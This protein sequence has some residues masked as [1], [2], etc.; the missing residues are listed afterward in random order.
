MRGGQPAAE[1]QFPWAAAL[2]L[3]SERNSDHLC[4][5]ALIPGGS[6]D[7]RWVLTCA[8][9]MARYQSDPHGIQATLATTRRTDTSRN[10]SVRRIHVHPA[11][12]RR[13]LTTHDIAVVELEDPVRNV[14]APRIETE[15]SGTSVPAG[16]Q[17][18]VVGWG[19]T[20][21][22]GRLSEYL[23]CAVVERRCDPSLGAFYGVDSRAVVFAGAPGVGI[24]PGDSGSA[25]VIGN[26]NGHA[27]VG[28]ASD[29]GAATADLYTATAPYADWIQAVCQ[30]P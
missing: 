7:S 4:C 13:R 16:G 22:P 3:A 10:A 21:Y 26:E 1:G 12:E 27:L 24:L 23:L 14:L 2:S 29:F 25:L 11:W 6:G 18:L 19:C 5:G 15:S 17:A 20:A 8:H 30:S 28:I 9:A